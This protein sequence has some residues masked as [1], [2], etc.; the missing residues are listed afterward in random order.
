MV[1]PFLSGTTF[2]S[3]TSFGTIEDGNE[4][5]AFA[6]SK[7]IIMWGWNPAYTFHGGNT[8]YYMR[9]AKQNGCKFVII[10]PQF[11][12][13]AAAYDAWWIPIKPNTDAAMLAAMAHYIFVNELQDQEFINAFCQGM[14]AGTMPDWAQGHENFKDYILG[15]NDGQPKSPE[16]AEPI[17]GVSAEDI[18]KL[19][20]MYATTKPAALKAHGHRDAVLMVNNITVWRL[21]CRL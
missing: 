4:D 21:L 20:H 3:L 7:L 11:T 15:V 8:F 5:D 13:S 9:Q 12:D 16:W 18:K 10:D 17:C 14:D 19:A 1:S 6:F 2:S